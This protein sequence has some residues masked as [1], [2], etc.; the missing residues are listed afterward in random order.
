MY[1]FF[2]VCLCS[3]LNIQF[4]HQMGQSLTYCKLQSVLSFIFVLLN[5]LV[6]AV[7]SLCDLSKLVEIILAIKK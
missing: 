7:Y 3:H 2:L 4:A 1:F 5:C 6:T